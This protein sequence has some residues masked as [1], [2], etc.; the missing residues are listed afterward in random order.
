MRVQTAEGRLAE[1]WF[2]KGSLVINHPDGLG[3]VYVSEFDGKGKY[4]IIAYRGTAA[5]PSYNYLIKDRER[6]EK[7]VSEFFD[8]LG[9]HKAL[10][11]NRRAEANKPHSLNVG[12][13]ITN[14]WGYDQTNVDCYQITKTTVNFVWLKPIASD[15]V[16]S[17]G[18][19]PMAGHVVPVPGQFLSRPEV[20]HKASGEYVTFKYGYGSKW[21]G[22]KTLYCSWYS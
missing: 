3:V 19:S 14:S 20:K 18:V 1:R 9:Q 2:P 4:Q 6:A 11:E 13:V 12:D 21:D 8:G 5:K 10:V 7:F 17:E 22:K 16:P 15:L